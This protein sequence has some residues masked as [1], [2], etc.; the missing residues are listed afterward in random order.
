VRLVATGTLTG[1]LAFERGET[2]LFQ[3]SP[4]SA[5]LNNT[6]SESVQ[7]RPI[8]SSLYQALTVTVGA[9]SS[10]SGTLGLSAD[11]VD[12]NDNF[13]AHGLTI[14]DVVTGTTT[15]A[16]RFDG[17]DIFA[18]QRNGPYRLT[19]VLLTDQTGATLVLAEV[20]DVYTTAAYQYT[21]FAPPKTLYLPLIRR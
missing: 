13:V 15:L 16:L 12:G 19:N 11:L 14:Q 8:F 20:Q 9:N 17:A 7:P 21:S 10:I 4:N 3:I 1:G 6:Y 18:S 2:L 5:A